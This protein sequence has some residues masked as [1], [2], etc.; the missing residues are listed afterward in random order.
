MLLGRMSVHKYTDMAYATCCLSMKYMARWAD[1]SRY[2]K[3]V[4][5]NPIKIEVSMSQSEKE[6]EKEEKEIILRSR[7]RI[8]EIILFVSV[9]SY[10]I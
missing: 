4:Q 8:P 9:C 3:Y 10:S 2:Y 5:V 7:I 6:E 1:Q